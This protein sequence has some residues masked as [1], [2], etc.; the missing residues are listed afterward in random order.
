[1]E[2]EQ[3]G[4][5][6][7]LVWEGRKILSVYELEADDI[8][9]HFET[10][11]DGVHV[12]YVKK[13]HQIKSYICIARLGTNLQREDNLDIS[14]ISFTDPCLVSLPG[15]KRTFNW[16]AF[17]KEVFFLN[18]ASFFDIQAK[19]NVDF[20]RALDHLAL[21][22]PSS[23]Q[24]F[25]NEPTGELPGPNGKAALQ[26][27]KVVQT[28]ELGS[29]IRNMHDMAE[30]DIVTKVGTDGNG[31]RMACVCSPDLL[32]VGVTTVRVGFQL[33][34]V[35]DED[36]GVTFTESFILSYPGVKKKGDWYEFPTNVFTPNV[37]NFFNANLARNIKYLKE[38]L[39]R[40]RQAEKLQDGEKDDPGDENH[41][42]NLYLS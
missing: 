24:L 13:R 19:Q 34:K 12:A 11:K 14:A 9:T 39:R 27:S 6:E 15:V 17:N 1:M 4:D 37:M 23:S 5:W 2:Q 42:S 36:P 41:S 31:K 33:Q 38:K 21:D 18:V 26:G 10:N 22:V 40:K 8:V 25:P 20:L 32:P 16:Y 7:E 30:G 35:K 28:D 29:L 3:D